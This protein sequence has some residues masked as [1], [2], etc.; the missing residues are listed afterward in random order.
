MLLY[1][2]EAPHRGA[3]NEYNNICFCG[4]KRKK[5]KYFSVENVHSTL[6]ISYS[7]RP[8]YLVRDNSS[9]RYNDLKY[10]ELIQN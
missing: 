6:G 1:S 2:L 5:Y 10:K 7:K 9:L 8:E 3:S 4:E